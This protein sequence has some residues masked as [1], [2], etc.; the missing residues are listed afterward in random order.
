MDNRSNNSSAPDVETELPGQDAEHGQGANAGWT[1]RRLLAGMALGAGALALPAMVRAS[2][3]S[4]TIDQDDWTHNTDCDRGFFLGQVV[5]QLKDGRVMVI[6][7][8]DENWNYGG[9]R[10]RFYHPDTDTWSVAPSLPDDKLICYVLGWALLKNGKLLVGGGDV[11]N[12]FDHPGDNGKC[13]LFD[14]ET[15][16]WAAT[17]AIPETI[18]GNTPWNPMVLLDDGNVLCIGACDST[19]EGTNGG[20]NHDGYQSAILKSYLYD[21]SAGTWSATGLM[22][23]GHE[24]GF[25]FPLHGNKAIVIGGFLKFA[26]GVDNFTSFSNTS[27]IYSGGS[28]SG[29]TVLPPVTRLDNLG[30][31]DMVSAELKGGRARAGAVATKKYIV[32]VGGQYGSAVDSDGSQ[33]LYRS[34]IIV[35]NIHA[36][37]WAVSGVAMPYTVTDSLCF[38]LDDDNILIAGGENMDIG[39]PTPKTFIFCISKATLTPSTDMPTVFRNWEASIGSG[40][41]GLLPY[42]YPDENQQGAIALQNGSF[43]SFGGLDTASFDGT[44]G[45]HGDTLTPDKKRRNRR[46]GED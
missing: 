36:N 40:P 34:S 12:G 10:N 37:S 21:T 32:L 17:G 9:D 6:G 39:L 41:V 33:L 22:A 35:Y 31:D 43:L 16:T 1:R 29:S 28:F 8:L 44:P 46:R 11:V 20:P 13:Y 2:E 42:N 19:Y 23:S 14:P 7:G 45:G 27:E 3:R 25:Y 4:G 18:W 30:E 15:D 38:A 24:A 26:P 5:Q